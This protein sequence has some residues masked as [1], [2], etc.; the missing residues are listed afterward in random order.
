[1]AAVRIKIKNKKKLKLFFMCR[2][3]NTHCVNLVAKLTDHK[4]KAL[5][6]A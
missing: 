4:G 3:F 5:D 6:L 2:S 1:M